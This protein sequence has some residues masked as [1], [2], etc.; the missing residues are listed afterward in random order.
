[1]K[2][3][4][5]SKAPTSFAIEGGGRR[6]RVPPEITEPLEPPLHGG[7]EVAVGEDRVVPEPAVHLDS[8]PLPEPALYGERVALPQ[9]STLNPRSSH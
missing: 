5:L 6:E 7:G 2:S 4:T 9:I 8:E 1:M 3:K